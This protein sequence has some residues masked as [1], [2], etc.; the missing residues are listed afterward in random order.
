MGIRV[1]YWVLVPKRSARPS[2]SVPNLCY[3]SRWVD[4]SRDRALRTLRIV[5]EQSTNWAHRP[6]HYYEEENCFNSFISTIFF[7]QMHMELSKVYWS[8]ESIIIESVVLK[9][10]RFFKWD[11]LSMVNLTRISDKIQF[12]K[13]VIYRFEFAKFSYFTEQFGTWF[14]V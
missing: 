5:N 3:S 9:L 12:I 4:D 7:F 2:I 8:I 10:P 11:H 13:C 14:H 1:A 6:Q